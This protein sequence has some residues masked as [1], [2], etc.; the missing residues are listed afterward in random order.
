MGTWADCSGCAGTGWAGEESPEIFCAT[1][2]GAGLL[3]HSAGAPVSENAAARVARHVARVTK[4]LGVA[5]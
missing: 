5:A 4:L 3:E 2:G 1:C